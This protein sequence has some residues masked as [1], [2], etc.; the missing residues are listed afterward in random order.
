M[1]DLVFLLFGCVLPLFSASNGNICYNFQ[2]LISF[3]VETET[4]S[5]FKVFISSCSV[6]S[7][8]I[9]FGFFGKSLDVFPRAVFAGAQ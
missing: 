2:L 8:C 3:S 4:V 6:C 9:P 7:F 5:V 1:M